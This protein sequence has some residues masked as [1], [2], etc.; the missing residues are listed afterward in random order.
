MPHHLMPNVLGACFARQIILLDVV[1]D[2]YAVLTERQSA[3]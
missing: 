3:V 2:R 1:H